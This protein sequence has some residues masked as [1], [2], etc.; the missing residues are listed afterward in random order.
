MSPWASGDSL[1]PSTLNRVVPSWVSSA[2]SASGLGYVN[3]KDYGAVGDG[4]TDDT[5]ALSNAFSAAA[6]A[7]SVAQIIFPPGRYAYTQS[8]PWARR[9]NVAFVGVGQVELMYTGTSALS[10]AV[11]FASDAANRWNLSLENVI[12]RSNSSASDGLRVRG[13]HHST[14]KNVRIAAAGTGAALRTEFTV[15]SVFDRVLATINENLAGTSLPPTGFVF[16][17]RTL[18]L[19]ETTTGNTFINCAVEGVAGDGVVLQEASFNNFVNLV[20]EGN[21]RNLVLSSVTAQGNKFHGLYTEAAGTQA[22]GVR[23]D[24]GQDNVFYGPHINQDGINL[25]GGARTE[26]YGGYVRAVVVGS[27]SSMAL[28][29]GVNWLSFA[30]SGRSTAYY[31]CYNRTTDTREADTLG[32][33]SLTARALTASH[34]TN[35]TLSLSDTTTSLLAEIRAATGDAAFRFNATDRFFLRRASGI[36]DFGSSVVHQT[37]GSA[38]SPASAYSSEASLGFYR[39]GASTQALS[40]GSFTAPFVGVSDTLRVGGSFDAGVISYGATDLVARGSAGKGLSLGAGGSSGYVSISSTGIVSL[41]TVSLRTTSASLTSLTVGVNEMALFI[42]GSSGATL[43]V[44]SGGTLYY[45]ASSAST[46]G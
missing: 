6:S 25:N 35:P 41:N 17:G 43:A 8:L 5:S 27:G 16:A 31:H 33:A 36:V 14:F 24:A 26:F 20:T 9:D 19:G 40:Y 29:N 38:Q 32:G 44:R 23:V 45:F 46:V 28:F 34:A 21:D 12:I 1:T 13:V 37:D 30:D 39:S 18:S 3:V 11:D 22:S 10:A 2:L 15:L 7:Y 42:G 4:S